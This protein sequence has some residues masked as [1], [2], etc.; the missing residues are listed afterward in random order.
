MAEIKIIYGRTTG[1][2]E[3]AHKLSPPHREPEPYAVS[4]PQRQRTL[5][6]IF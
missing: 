4:L 3:S 6:Q 1:C 5:R 2:T